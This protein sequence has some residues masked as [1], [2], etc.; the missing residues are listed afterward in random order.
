MPA[1]ADTT[2]AVL[3]ETTAALERLTRLLERDVQAREEVARAAR[4]HQLDLLRTAP[5]RLDWKVLLTAVPGLAG[6][7]KEVPEEYRTCFGSEAVV[8]CPCGNLPGIPRDQTERC[9]CGRFYL[10]AVTVFVANS[11]PASST[12]NVD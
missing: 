10:Y 9:R 1:V 8:K 11:P 4:D 7:F 3:A 6:Q 12:A 2:E 5:R